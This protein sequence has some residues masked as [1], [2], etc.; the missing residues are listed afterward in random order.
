MPDTATVSDRDRLIALNRDYIN[1]VQTMDVQRFDEI[2]SD[3]FVCSN[4]D[5]SLVGRAAFLEQ[6]ARPIA[7]SG[8]EARDV[9]VRL[10]GDFAIIHA[11]TTYNLPD[12]RPG[13]GRYTDIWARRN[14]QWLAVAAHV[15]RC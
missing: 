11:R 4:P 5:G 6:T 12:G 15:T 10:M 8:L 2:L 7:I 13:A 14:G 9:D 1:S 3:D